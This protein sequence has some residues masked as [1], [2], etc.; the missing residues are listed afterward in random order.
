M[1]EFSTALAGFFWSWILPL[2]IR[3]AAE[4]VLLHEIARL[5][6]FDLWFAA[7]ANLTANEVAR[8]VERRDQAR[9][10]RPA[11]RRNRHQSL[12]DPLP[13]PQ[14]DM[15]MALVSP[16]EA[17]AGLRGLLHPPAGVRHL[18]LEPAKRPVRRG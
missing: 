4:H 11:D 14:G 6:R 5:A 7:L 13:A 15:T 16:A 2:T 10:A 3:A 9:G 18:R 12:R 17:S 1:S 8:L